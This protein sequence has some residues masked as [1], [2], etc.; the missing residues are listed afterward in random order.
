MSRPTAAPRHWPYPH[1]TLAAVRADQARLHDLA[2]A[3]GKRPLTVAESDEAADL[4]N[5]EIA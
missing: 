4:I 1:R 5:R 2:V 3:A